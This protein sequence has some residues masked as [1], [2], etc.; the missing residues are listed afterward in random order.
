MMVMMIYC[1]LTVDAQK[2]DLWEDSEEKAA[3]RQSPLQR[4]TYDK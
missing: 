4:A 2:T 1:L 3:Q